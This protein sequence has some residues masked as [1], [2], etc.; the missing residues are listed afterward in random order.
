MWRL[1]IG[2]GENDPFLFST[3]NFTGR[4]TWEFDPH[5]G[6]PQE[7][8]EIEEARQNYHQNRFQVK[9]SSDL[10]WR[11]QCLREK[12]FKQTIPPLK[13]QEGEEITHETATAALKRAV[14]FTAALQSSHGHWPAEFSG[15]LFYTPPLVMCL[16]ITG[17][18]NVVL[19]AEHRKE[20]KRCIYNHQ[21]KDGGW[22]LAVGSHSS[23]FGTAFNYVCLRLLGEG[24]DAGEDNGMARGRKWILDHGG[25]TNILSWGKIWLSILGVFDWS[26]CNPMPPEYWILPSILPIHPANMMCYCRNTYMPMSYLYGKKFVGRITPLILQ[27]REELYI[28]PY[29]KIKWGKVRHLCAQVDIYYPHPWMQDLVWDSLYMITEPLLNVWPFTKLREKALQETIKHIH[30]EDESSRYIT[31]GSVE[32]TLCMLACWVEDPDGDSFKKHLARVPDFL[33]VAED[34]MKVQTLGSQSW[35]I[36]Y[37]IEAF[38][39]A[40]R[41]LS[42]SETGPTLMKGHDFIKKSQVRDNPV[43]DFKSMFRC[44]SKG[45]WT[46]S[47][48]DHGLPAS[49]SLSENLKCCLLLSMMPSEIVGDKIELERVYDAVNLLL[50]MQSKNGGVTIW[51]PAGGPSWLEMLN[52]VDFLENIVTE[53][54]Y[55]ELTSSALQTMV[56]FKK[57]HPE[58]RKEEM[59]EFIVRAAQYLE[60][61]QNPDG[62]WYGV[63]GICFTYGAWFALKGLAAAGKTYYNCPTMRNG[64]RFLLTTQGDDG[65]WGESYLSCPN[66]KLIPLEGRRSNLVQTAWALMGLIHAQQAERDPTP[67]HRAAKLL[68]NSQ[69]ENGGFPQQELTGAFFSNCMLH[70]ANYCITFPLMALAEYCSCMQVPL[71]SAAGV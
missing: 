71:A 58:Y 69:M 47:D 39:A 31:I 26:G 65:G 30:Y 22:G 43:G 13:I 54:E 62:S 15:P 11:M 1:K 38:L 59:E 55:V 63:W 68:I 45:S 37:I 51:E 34:G 50:T 4:Q 64:V 32:K 28:Q 8:A 9:P 12:N 44:T 35:D 36:A 40:T 29:N 23:M 21:N 56:L 25:V 5:A 10:L 41:N 49:D 33:W 24:P 61:T 42:A 19:S 6:T 16:Y 48:Q 27:L 66:K 7:R 52:P 70:Y 60:D 46:L 14:R 17:H 57:L 2:E 20:V 67:L 18:L 3:N 53:H